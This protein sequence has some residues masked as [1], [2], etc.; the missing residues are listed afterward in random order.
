MCWR[1]R[2][3]GG[4]DEE[5][6][7]SD[8]GYRALILD[9][10]REKPGNGFDLVSTLEERLKDVFDVSPSTLYPVLQ[11]LED[12]GHVTV[13]QEGDRKVYTITDEGRKYVESRDEALGSFWERVGAGRYRAEV[14]DLMRTL[15]SLAWEVGANAQEK[16]IEPDDLRAI[17]EAI[18]RARQEIESKLAG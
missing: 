3:S 13:T 15:K 18:E 2:W 17:R 5:Q 12:L 16:R 6:Q 14:W 4:S 11:L 8:R 1:G 7:L 10:L 9:L